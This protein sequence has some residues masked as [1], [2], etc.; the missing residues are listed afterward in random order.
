MKNLLKRKLR[1]GEYALGSWISIPNPEVPE[2]LSLAN[3][4]WF[5]FDMEHGPLNVTVLENLI[6]TTSENVT[7]L[8]RVPANEL[9]YVK[10]ALDVGAQGVMVPMVN[11][12]TDA[13]KATSFSK[14]PPMGARGLGARRASEYFAEHSEYLKEA[15]EETMVVVQIETSD[16]VKN[17]E[18]IIN[19][20]GVD[21]WFVGP[22]DLA[23]SLGHVGDPNCEAVRE[24]MGKVLRI[25]I[26]ADVAGGT[27]AFD[28]ESARA[29]LK[30]G[31][32]LLAIGS[33]DYFLLHGANSAVASVAPER[34]S[35]A[36][37]HY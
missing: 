30:R 14:Y 27:L 25:G 11:N 33:D 21:A 7:P 19:S 4:D 37:G 9:V 18:E 10:Q 15:N 20:K 17:A 29:F 22:N 6:Q 34:R 31:F 5:L 8:V 35:K 3:F 16:A 2:I 13:L 26:K 32:R 1:H 28:T 24:A 12:E 36:K 23:A